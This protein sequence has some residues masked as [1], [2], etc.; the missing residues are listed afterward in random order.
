MKVLLI[1]AN[2][3]QI[4]VP[5]MPYGMACVAEAART[6]GYDVQTVNLMTRDDETGVL[7]NVLT[8]YQP[9][10][11]G[12]SVRNIDNV[13]LLNEQRYIDGVRKIAGSHFASGPAMPLELSSLERRPSPGCRIHTTGTA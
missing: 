1:S 13:N 5:V 4:N 7:E 2:T 12:I 10:V 3:E 9:D 6:A 8:S 11:I